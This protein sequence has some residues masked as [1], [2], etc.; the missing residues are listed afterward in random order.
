MVEM[1]NHPTVAALA[2]RLGE[3]KPATALD[4]VQDR[5]EKQRL[6]RERQRR[7]MKKLGGGP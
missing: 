4:G 6:A 7:A 3:E 5:I 2:E 1:F